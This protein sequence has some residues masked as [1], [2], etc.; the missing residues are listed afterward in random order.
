MKRAWILALALVVACSW[1]VTPAWA[2][3]GC[4]KS[5]NAKTA[6]ASCSIDSDFPKMVMMVGDKS[7]DCPMAAEKAATE[8]KSK[9]VYAVAGEKFECKDKAME[10]LACAS[11]GYIKR[12]TSVATVVDGKVIFASDKSCSSTCGSSASASAKD[13]KKSCCMA[14]ASAKA[15]ACSSKV[16]FMTQSQIDAE[17][18]NAKVVKYVVAG[19]SFDCP[20]EAAKVRDEAVAA[21][22]LVSMKYI[23]D[24]KEVGSSTEVCPMAKKAGKVQYMVN[25]EKTPCETTARISLAKA[26]YE[27]LTKKA[28][29]KVAA[30]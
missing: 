24:G 15:A 14:G 18:K 16:V 12:F 2:G 6:S 9:I 29:K 28:E 17:V 20:K 19:K 27:A 25:G 4:C 10:A 3:P 21:I 1:G 23:V 11:E 5:T 30:M 8:G 22:K 26:Q 13:G 7:F